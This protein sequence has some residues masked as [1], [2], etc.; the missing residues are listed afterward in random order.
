MAEFILDPEAI[1]KR[2]T[3]KGIDEHSQEVGYYFAKEAYIR[4]ELTNLYEM[5]N[6]SLHTAKRIRE[7]VQQEK[8]NKG[9]KVNLTVCSKKGQKR[10]VKMLRST[11][12][13]MAECCRIYSMD[14][15]RKDAYLL[16]SM[17]SN[18]GIPAECIISIDFGGTNYYTA[19]LDADRLPQKTEGSTHEEGT[20]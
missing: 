8:I 19:E 16:W 6:H 20:A 4:E 10:T 11:L 12:A 1:I 13:N 2:Y 5:P 3:T 9:L 18:K 15:T 7:A 14:H 17:F